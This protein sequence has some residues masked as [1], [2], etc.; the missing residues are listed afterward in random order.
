[1][2]RTNIGGGGIVFWRPVVILEKCNITHNRA[3]AGGG[4]LADINATGK[5]KF[6]PNL[7]LLFCSVFHVMLVIII[8]LRA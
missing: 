3:F 4:I 2:E 1:M 6:N 8:I 5:C 7:T